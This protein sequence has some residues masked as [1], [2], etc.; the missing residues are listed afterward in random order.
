[1]CFCVC[2]FCAAC[3]GRRPP[4]IIPHPKPLE[5]GASA[6]TGGLL[7]VA[8]VTL[9]VYLGW[10]YVHGRLVSAA[11]PYEES[12]WYDGQVSLSGWCGVVCVRVCGGGRRH[13]HQAL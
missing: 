10:H 5:F 6:A 9:R 3:A 1:M 11:L 12:G 2:A 13:H 8:L 7:V 4:T